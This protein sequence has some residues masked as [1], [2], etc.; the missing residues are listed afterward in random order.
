MIA[1]KDTKQNKTLGMVL[2]ILLT[3]S[4]ILSSVLFSK[5]ER[6]YVPMTRFLHILRPKSVGTHVIVTIHD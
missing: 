6:Y 4:K 1:V 2:F 5:I 3:D